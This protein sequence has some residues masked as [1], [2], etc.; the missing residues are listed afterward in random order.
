MTFQVLGV[1]LSIGRKAAGPLRP[2]ESRAS[3]GLWAP[4]IREP[5]T[6][7]WQRNDE[8]S[9]D[10]A[11]TNPYVFTCISL[12][13]ADIAKLDL[14]LMALD[15]DGIWYETTNP[16]YS[17]VL[18]R[19][20]R[21]QTILK[22]VE[23]WMTSK[24]VQGNAYVLKERDLR[25][26]VRAL[27]VLNPACV[28]PLVAPDGAVYYELK[29]DELAGILGTDAVT[30]PASEI[31]HDQYYCPGHPL[32][33]VSPLA[34]CGAAALQGKIIQEQSGKFFSMGSKPGGILIAP[35]AISQEQAGRIRDYWATEFSGNNVGKV[36]VLSDGMKYEPMTVNAADAQLI[37]QL[38]WTGETICGCYKVPK[39]MAGIGPAASGDVEATWQQ[40][41]AQCLQSQIKSIQLTLDDGLGLA[42]SG[43]GVQF[44]VDD[45]IR[46]NTATK[47]KAAADSIGAG[48]LSPNE[49]RK[50]YYGLGPV[51]GGDTPYLQQ[52]NYSLAALDERDKT[53]PLV[54]PEPAPAAPPPEPEPDDELAPEPDAELPDVKRAPYAAVMLALLKKDWYGIAD[55]R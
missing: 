19:P 35:G 14:R 27:Y 31:L 28:T 8:I 33:G 47:T 52:Q 4:I 3:R 51:K 32:I 20:N 23:Q 2:I 39:G 41:Y 44:D 21:Y 10:A 53:N 42:G 49:A 13:A 40:Y 16:A 38:G 45:L 43:Y 37:E 11:T 15:A 22:F 48:A 54:A 46:M 25:G 34:A 26:V 55:G 12:I 6:G 29:R 30:V 24:L 5:Y 36:A 1:E 17:P 18:R 9:A 7:A 50:K